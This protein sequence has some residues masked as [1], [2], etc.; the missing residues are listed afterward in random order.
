M[1]EESINDKYQKLKRISNPKI[2]LLF[3]AY[4]FAGP[5]EYVNDVLMTENH[6][7][8]TDDWRMKE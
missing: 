6:L 1:L 2:L 7:I 3:D 4:G 8:K 5:K